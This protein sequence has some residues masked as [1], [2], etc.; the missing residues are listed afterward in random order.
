MDSGDRVRLPGRDPGAASAWPARRG[1]ERGRMN[2]L[3]AQLREWREAIERVL[4]PWWSRGAAVALIAFGI[5]LP[6]FFSAASNFVNKEVLALA[7]VVF[8]LGLNVVVGVAG[9]RDLG[10]V[11]L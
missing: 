4:P 11:A 6:F 10:S 8:A 7:C 1:D 3:Q 9:L 5:V 2:D